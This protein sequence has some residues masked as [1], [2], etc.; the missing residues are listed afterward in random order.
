MGMV[1]FVSFGV[2]FCIA[3]PLVS[4]G[5]VLLMELPLLGEVAGALV[6]ANAPVLHSNTVDNAKAVI[7]IEVFSRPTLTTM[8]ADLRALYHA[9]RKV[10]DPA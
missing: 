10:F 2:V 9:R 3:L 1:L 6:C 8:E 4:P 7:F 5:C